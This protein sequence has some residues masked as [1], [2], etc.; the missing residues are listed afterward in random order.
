LI[1]GRRRRGVAL[2]LPNAPSNLLLQ[3]NPF[4]MSL[5]WEYAT[6][7]EEGFR[8]YRSSFGDPFVVVAEVPSNELFFTDA[9]V[10]TGVIY[11]YYVVAFNASGESSHSNHVSGEIEI[12]A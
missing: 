9:N 3:I 5:T 4:D 8:A 11:T 1:L 2:Q 6:N 7:T 10:D 12:G